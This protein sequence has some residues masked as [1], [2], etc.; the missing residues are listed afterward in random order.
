MSKRVWVMTVTLGVLWLRAGAHVLGQAVKG[1]KRMSKREQ[2]DSLLRR[3]SGIQSSSRN[4]P[5]GTKHGGFEVYLW[6]NYA[7][8]L[9]VGSVSLELNEE[10]LDAAI[11]FLNGYIGYSLSDLEAVVA[12][13][14]ENGRQTNGS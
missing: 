4:T 11:D 13:A 8:E 1:K 10:E 12:W 2:I 3:L 6:R 5:E 7:P 14:E 9:V